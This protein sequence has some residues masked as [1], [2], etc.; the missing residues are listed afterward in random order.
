MAK[1]G[2]NNRTFKSWKKRNNYAWQSYAS[3]NTGKKGIPH[4]L[5]MLRSY[6]A[7]GLLYKNLSYTIPKHS[8]SQTSYGKKMY[9]IRSVKTRRGIIITYRANCTKQTVD[10]K[11]MKIKY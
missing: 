4:K 1:L 11:S 2:A 10:N 6:A 9:L 3:K 8:E 5:K 7:N